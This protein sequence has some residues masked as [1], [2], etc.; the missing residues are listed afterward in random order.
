LAASEIVR[1]DF[2]PFG[3]FVFLRDTP[4]AAEKRRTMQA[5]ICCVRASG[6]CITF[7]IVDSKGRKAPTADPQD[8]S[9]E[10]RSGDKNV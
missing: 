5:T 10:E 7:V 1:R 8:A 9:R 3:L 4:A 2:R 6:R